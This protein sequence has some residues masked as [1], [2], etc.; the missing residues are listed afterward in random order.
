MEHPKVSSPLIAEIG[1]RLL[2]GFLSTRSPYPRVVCEVPA[3]YQLSANDVCR[4]VGQANGASCLACE[5]AK[6]EM[7]LS[8]HRSPHHNATT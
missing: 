7:E 1:P 6:T 4:P 2:H 8:R 3:K 5:T